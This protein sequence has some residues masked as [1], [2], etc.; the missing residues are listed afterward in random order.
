ML[1][2]TIRGCV[3]IALLLVLLIF[4]AREIFFSVTNPTPRTTST[5]EIHQ[6]AKTEKKSLI[7]VRF[8]Y[9]S[10]VFVWIV[11]LFDEHLVPPLSDVCYALVHFFSFCNGDSPHAHAACN[12]KPLVRTVAR[13]ALTYLCP[14]RVRR[15]SKSFAWS[16]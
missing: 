15:L 5:K 12:R 13:I 7:S 16:N 2:E 14:A 9:I 3:M 6:T 4:E 1:F 10:Y 11:L 8:I